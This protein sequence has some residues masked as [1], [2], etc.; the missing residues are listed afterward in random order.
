MAESFASVRYDGYRASGCGWEQEW[1]RSWRRS[2]PTLSAS[3]IIGRKQSVAAGPTPNPPRR[4]SGKLSCRRRRWCI[5]E[6]YGR[7]LL[8]ERAIQDA[9]SQR[10][11]S[12][13]QQE[14]LR[15]SIGSIRDVAC[16]LAR[17]SVSPPRAPLLGRCNVDNT[18][19]QQRSADPRRCLITPPRSEHVSGHRSTHCRRAQ[20]K[21]KALIGIPDTIVLG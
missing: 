13:R 7:V 6:I 11:G 21:L 3:S 10:V 17:R 20:T 16:W 9:A 15:P 5:C 2:L 14:P 8:S 1:V 12:G 18:R 4:S 19:E